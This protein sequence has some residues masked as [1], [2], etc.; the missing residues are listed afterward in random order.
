MKIERLFSAAWLNGR[1]LRKQH[2]ATELKQTDPNIEL[3]TTGSFSR[4]SHM[5]LLQSSTNY[6]SPCKVS[7]P[8]QDH[9]RKYTMINLIT[10]KMLYKE[11]K[12]RR[13]TTCLYD[14]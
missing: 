2:L 8:T 7:N 9:L 14:K 12:K 1:S 11:K 3:S 6:T 13:K 5:E 4:F 10:M